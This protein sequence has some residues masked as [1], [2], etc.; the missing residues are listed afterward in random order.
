MTTVDLLPWLTA[1]FRLGWW[2]LVDLAGQWTSLTTDV[3]GRK[4]VPGRAAISR[5]VHVEQGGKRHKQS[6]KDIV[7]TVLVCA[8]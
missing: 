1:T 8:V 3:A 7:D 5:S 2:L 6:A 4:P